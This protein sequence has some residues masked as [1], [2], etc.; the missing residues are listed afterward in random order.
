MNTAAAVGRAPDNERGRKGDCNHHPGLP[1][2]GSKQVTGLRGG[3]A[4]PPL[5]SQPRR[6]NKEKELLPPML[7]GTATARLAQPHTVEAEH[8]SLFP[9]AGEGDTQARA[10]S[11]QPGNSPNPVRALSRC[12]NC[13]RL[14]VTWH[15]QKSHQEVLHQNGLRTVS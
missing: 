10:G 11:L 6:K 12:V 1:R 7:P 14:F 2:V 8:G 15:T 4:P 13:N 9:K 3:S 5:G